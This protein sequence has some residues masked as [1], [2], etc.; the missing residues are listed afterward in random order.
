MFEIISR[1]FQ[2]IIQRNLSEPDEILPWL[3]VAIYELGEENAL[4]LHERLMVFWDEVKG[5]F[6]AVQDVLAWLQSNSLELAEK[7]Q[8]LDSNIFCTLF[9]IFSVHLNI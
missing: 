5:E 9:E 2:S 6:A 1:T 3:N 8:K 4:D 7:F